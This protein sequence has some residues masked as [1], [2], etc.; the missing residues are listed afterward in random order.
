MSNSV[1]SKPR[2]PSFAQQIS[3]R[4]NTNDYV[5]SSGSSKHS[6]LSD[7]SLYSTDSSTYNHQTND[8]SSQFSPTQSVRSLSTEN[9]NHSDDIDSRSTT[10]KKTN[11][12][13]HLQ[14][15]VS[16]EMIVM[17]EHPQ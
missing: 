11:S 9:E 4:K 3:D 2:N 8:D 7:S 14:Y 12:D 10:S 1:V 13:I 15:L 16:I 6:N 17:I 5:L